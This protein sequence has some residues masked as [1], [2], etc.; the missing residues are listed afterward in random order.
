[1]WELREDQT[2]WAL[3]TLQNVDAV[4]DQT[5]AIARR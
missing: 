4:E 3:V 5:G 1:M 2:L